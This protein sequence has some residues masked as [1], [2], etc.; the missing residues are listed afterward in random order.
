MT[1]QTGARPAWRWAWLL[2]GA[3]I[4]AVAAIVL[5]WPLALHLTDHLIDH[6][7]PA[8]KADPYLN[9]WILSW[10][11]HALTHF[12]TR[13]F[14][15]NIFYPAPDALAFSDTLL[16][17]QPLF[18]PIY[19]VTG[20]LVLAYNLTLLGAFILNGLCLAC[21][22][23]SVTRRSLPALVAGSFYAFAAVRFP[24]LVHLQL[25]SAWWAPLAFLALDA[26]LREPRPLRMAATVLAVWC[27]F[28]S[29]A[30]L[31]LMLAWLLVPYAI[32]RGWRE[33]WRRLTP[34]VLLDLATA[35]LL[36]A[37]L[38]FPVATP[39]LRS[40][41]QW[42]HERGLQ[43]QLHYSAQPT[44]FL[45]AY[46]TNWLYGDL[47]RPFR[48]QDAQ[49][50]TSLC[51]GLLPWVLACAGFLP[52]RGTRR[53]RDGPPCAVPPGY[54]L[55][56][57]LAVLL[58][59]GPILIWGDE[60]AQW[61]LPYLALYLWAPGF[62]A[63]RV[64]ARFF[65]VGLVP[66]AV[67]TGVAVARLLAWI[68]RRW[69][70]TAKA[71]TRLTAIV[72]FAGIMVESSHTPVPLQRAQIA[73]NDEASTRLR[74]L[75][76]D[77]AIL[78]IP[79][80]PF[81]TLREAIRM[82]RSTQHWASMVNGY[83]GF[84]PGSFFELTA[85]V[86]EPG[87]DDSVLEALEAIGV[88]TLVVHLDELR[89]EDRALWRQDPPRFRRLEPLYTTPTLR[90][91][92]LKGPVPHSD[93]LEAVLQVPSRLPVGGRLHLELQL[94]APADKPWVNPGPLGRWPVKVSWIP[95]DPKAPTLQKV[96]LYL[97]TVLPAGR[98]YMTI[99]P[100]ETP[101]GSGVFRLEV[102]GPGF[103]VDREITLGT[104][105]RA[106]SLRAGMFW[107]GAQ[108]VEAEAGTPVTIHARIRNQGEA[109]WGESL[110]GLAKGITFRHLAHL[111][112]L[113]FW[114][115]PLDLPGQG[116]EWP[117]WGAEQHTLW[118]ATPQSY[119]GRFALR[120]RWLREG[121]SISSRILPLPRDVFPGQDL[122][123]SWVVQA[124]NDPGPYDL[125][126]TLDA[127]MLEP[128]PGDNQQ[129]RLRVPARIHARVG[130][131]A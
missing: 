6:N 103:R 60:P 39:Y 89:E 93:S 119:L 79:V 54:L 17:N 47:T 57:G 90:L 63:M 86:N 59:L 34:R 69:P 114:W 21:L 131:P 127:P 104:V 101:G 62:R 113:N 120:L 65:L 10:G 61:P 129:N 11:I 49:W 96:P 13:L 66:L 100:L 56:A 87:L 55:V 26:W 9:A 28:L 20:N 109:I 30:Y 8:G 31:G 19:A 53:G 111:G 67:S 64:P 108:R 70:E 124:P 94:N 110:E 37:V 14:Q 4:Y 50:Q 80:A 51:L 5:T 77:G 74:E 27:Q 3:G 84:W 25:L 95:G 46:E 58:S 83:S 118:V 128:I 106:G 22:T 122:E 33:R 15:A 38:F 12:P 115:A 2:Y 121:R 24:D 41:A 71:A 98:R 107:L 48:R 82:T 73:G 81:A 68:E 45:A 32:R 117:I 99:L 78:E 42:G 123:L 126:L 97:P 105:S 36:A 18:A 40:Q 112:G 76:R 88:R 43:D 75:A 23:H 102:R 1:P 72:L 29:S 91:F 116:S 44:S 16:G 52:V 85:L 92:R 7:H 130:G 125:E 35:A